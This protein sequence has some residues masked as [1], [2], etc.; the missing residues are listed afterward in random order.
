MTAR[1][2]CLFQLPCVPTFVVLQ[3]GVIVTFVEV[4]QHRGEDF[5]EFFR[6]T[7]SF[8]AGFEKLTAADSGEEGGGG[9]DVFVGGE[10]SLFGTDA[11]GHNGGG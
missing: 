2:R 8:G 7:D 4:F 11:D 3:A 1:A 9:E 6:E 5:G 10:E